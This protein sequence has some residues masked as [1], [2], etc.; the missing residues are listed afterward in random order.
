MLRRFVAESA[1]HFWWPAEFE[2][3]ENPDFGN[4]KHLKNPEHLLLTAPSIYDDGLSFWTP[5]FQINDIFC[6]VCC[7]VCILPVIG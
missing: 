7:K 3:E 5:P 4:L 1:G 2:N 6:L